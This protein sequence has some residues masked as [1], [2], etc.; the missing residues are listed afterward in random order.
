MNNDFMLGFTIAHTGKRNKL[1]A[2]QLEGSRVSNSDF[3]DS[4]TRFGNIDQHQL[5]QGYMVH[6]L[7][8]RN[9]NNRA[10]RRMKELEILNDLPYHLNTMKR[11]IELNT[12]K[13]QAKYKA[14][15]TVDWLAVEVLEKS[16]REWVQK[17]MW[18]F[19]GH[20]NS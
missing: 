10:Y 7:M 5:E 2:W 17:S 13:I 9:F 3:A 6:A 12:Q 20:I 15:K 16:I 19:N 11:N 14:D 1:Q 18:V 4:T 8:Q